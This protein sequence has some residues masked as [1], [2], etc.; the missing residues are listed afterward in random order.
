MVETHG[1]MKSPAS[2]PDESGDPGI[3]VEDKAG[4]D[5]AANFETKLSQLRRDIAK[6]R[7]DVGAISQSPAVKASEL[8]QRRPWSAMAAAL[9]VGVYLG[10]RMHR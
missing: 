9:C 6:L 3:G 4:T 7:E 1:S 10:R 5:D 2:A 8:M